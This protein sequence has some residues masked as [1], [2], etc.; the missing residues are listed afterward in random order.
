MHRQDCAVL[1]SEWNSKAKTRRG[2][3]KKTTSADLWNE[4]LADFP[5]MSP[6]ISLVFSVWQDY[7][8]SFPKIC[9][10]LFTSSSGRKSVEIGFRAERETAGNNIQTPLQHHKR[11][12][13]E[14]C[15]LFYARS[16]FTHIYLAKA[17]RGLPWKPQKQ[18]A[19][20]LSI[21]ESSVDNWSHKQ[22]STSWNHTS[23]C[24]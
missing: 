10:H 18:M 15:P 19:A 24:P 6:T 21:L 3:M 20:F 13:P 8:S 11:E 4:E 16:Q 23:T 12:F 17:E 7:K 5:V 22:G 14:R 9:S 2:L 1:K